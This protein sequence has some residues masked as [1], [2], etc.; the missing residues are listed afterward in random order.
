MVQ[1]LT[2]REILKEAIRNEIL[3]ESLYLGLR[4]RVNNQDSREAFRFLAEEEEK[5]R[6]F[7]E[8]YLQGKLR[9]GTLSEGLVVDY[10][11]A[12]FLEQPEI[13]PAMELKD[14]FL[15]AANKEKS[16][17]D[18]YTCLSQIHPAG[19]IQH[20]FQELAAQE[21]DHKKKVETMYSEVAFPQTGGG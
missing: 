18:L 3:S 2:L 13:T 5:H 10:K 4:Q 19:K 15:L 14:V 12:E 20:L 7:L 17:F 6:R 9:E 11:I 8:D 21:L 16:T 1:Q